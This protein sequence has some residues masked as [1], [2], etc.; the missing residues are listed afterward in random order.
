[1]THD[2]EVAPAVRVR[3]AGPAGGQERRLRVV[4]RA[5][6][7]LDGAGADRL[8]RCLSAL[9]G[10][11]GLDLDVDLSAVPVLDLRVARALRQARQRLT[12]RDGSLRVRDGRAWGNEPPCCSGPFGTAKGQAGAGARRR[13]SAARASRL[14]VQRPAPATS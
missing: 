6:G 7:R 11:R 12:R 8:D 14:P 4:V 3:A 1:M 5:Q 2:D 13:R 9:S 10:V